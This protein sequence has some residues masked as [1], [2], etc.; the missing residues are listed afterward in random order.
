MSELVGDR[1]AKPFHPDD[2]EWR[3][4]KAGVSDHGPWAQGLPYLQARAIMQR[5]DDVVGIDAWQDSYDRIE[6]GFICSLT[7]KLGPAWIQKEG[8]ASDTDIEPLKGAESGAFKRAASKFGIGRYLYNLDVMFMDFTQVN[9]KTKGAKY[10]TIQGNGYYYVAPKL[11]MW[12]LP[13]E[14]KKERRG[15]TKSKPKPGDKNCPT[16]ET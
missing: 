3:I 5:L 10:I 11:P 8:V 4:I 6:N 16:K 14:K 9:R 12:A 13:E 2:I 7:L 15:V 1:L